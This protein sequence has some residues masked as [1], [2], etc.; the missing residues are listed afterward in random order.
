M[1]QNRLNY[2][3]MLC[4]GA[5]IS[6]S[7]AS[8]IYCSPSGN[9]NSGNG[10]MSM[11]YRNV[12]HAVSMATSGDVIELRQGNYP[13]DEIRI[14]ISNLTI[15]SFAGEKATITCPTNDIDMASCIWYHE[16]DITGGLLE[17]LEIIGGYY[18]GI[19]LESNWDWGVPANQRRGTSNITIRNCNIHHTGRDCIKLTPGCQ[20]ID[21]VSCEIHHSGVGI[22]NDPNDPNAE[23]ID[24]VNSN[25][26]VH[27]CYFH[28]IST[29][30]LYAKGGAKDCIIEENLLMNIGEGG[31]LAGF[32]TDSDWFDEVNNP[33]YYE[34]IHTIIRNNIIVNTGGAGIGFFGAKDCEAYNNT[35]VTA[36]PKFHSPL[37]FNTGEI[38]LSATDVKYPKNVNVRVRNNIFVDQSGTTED[39]LTVE[40]RENSLSGTSTINHN[41]YY[42][43]T[44]AA[45]FRNGSVWPNYDFAQWKSAMSFDANGMETNPNINANHHLTSNS[46]CINAGFAIAANTRDYDGGARAGTCDIGADEYNSGIAMNTPP[47]VGTIGT[48]VISQT[49]DIA[50]SKALFSFQIA[51]NPNAGRFLL[52]L[53]EMIDIQDIYLLDS[54]GTSRISLLFDNNNFSSSLSFDLENALNTGIYFLVV[55]SKNQ[56]KSVQKMIVQP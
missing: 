2:L 24:N 29:N 5:F 52:Q 54:K 39:D 37:F 46:P 19:K 45:S 16:P 48:G 28:D 44:G 7:F 13:S 23:G 10:S 25:M 40:I 36:S 51:P 4:L 33:D 27:N 32:Y 3:F 8:T 31:I 15:R 17:N 55:E 14:D 35:V 18:Y 43:T 38:W 50:P 11:P 30:G 53:P 26:W 22:G 56:G 20:N 41:L 1:K 12:E 49:T 47:S 6:P 21:I 9:D 42:K 34:S